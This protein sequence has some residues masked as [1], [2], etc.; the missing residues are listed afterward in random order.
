MAHYCISVW[1][2]CM[3]LCIVNL[4][5]PLGRYPIPRP[6]IVVAVLERLKKDLLRAQGLIFGGDVTPIMRRRDLEGII[7]YI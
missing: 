5:M 6:D 1:R 4:V 3:G 7:S 2:F